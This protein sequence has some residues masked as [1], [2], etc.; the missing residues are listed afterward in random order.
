MMH[1]QIAFPD[2]AVLKTRIALK[3]TVDD[4]VAEG[5]PGTLADSR[6]L[7]IDFLGFHQRCL[8]PL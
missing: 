2:D 5:N 3:A 6:G 4:F 7:I 8:T 1:R